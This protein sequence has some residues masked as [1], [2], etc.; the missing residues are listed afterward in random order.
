MFE[1]ISEG[2]GIVK[3]IVIVMALITAMVGFAKFGVAFLKQALWV[4]IVIGVI[5]FI[6]PNL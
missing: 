6:V 3:L 5:I 1:L 2:L 4:A